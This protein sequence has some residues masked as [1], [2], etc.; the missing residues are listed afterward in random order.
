[1]DSESRMSPQGFHR[2][3][4]LR[5]CVTGV[6]IKKDLNI[7]PVLRSVLLKKDKFQAMTSA[8]LSIFSI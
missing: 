3:E 6:N 4:T 8:Q 5:N 7:R 2:V 1:M